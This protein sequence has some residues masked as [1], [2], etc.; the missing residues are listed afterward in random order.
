MTRGNNLYASLRY[1]Q[2]Y[3]EAD[4]LL[5]QQLAAVRANYASGHWREGSAL[6]RLAS[7]QLDRGRVDTAVVL[8][9]EAT[10]LYEETLGPD[11]AWTAG[12]RAA[13][14]YALARQGTLATGERHLYQALEVLETVDP[15]ATTT[16]ISRHHTTAW[17]GLGLIHLRRGQFAEAESLL[18]A[19]HEALRDGSN[20]LRTAQAQQYLNELQGATGLPDARIASQHMP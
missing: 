10:R 3:E 12:A 13:L 17:L 5:R 16:T 15:E 11:H 9:G 20:E 6:E 2:R 8:L 7:L 19:S 14:G 1:Q 4:R 18:T